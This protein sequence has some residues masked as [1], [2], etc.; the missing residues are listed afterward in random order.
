M[1]RILTMIIR[2]VTGQ[3]LNRGIDAGI[4]RAARGS[5]GAVTPAQQA[6]TRQNANRAKQALRLL[7]R[8]ARF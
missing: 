3:L 6:Q 1:D 5:G 8:F 4:D 2:R 7:R